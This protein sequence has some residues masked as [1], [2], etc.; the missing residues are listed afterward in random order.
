[1]STT[2][3]LSLRVTTAIVTTT[4]LLG[5]TACAKDTAAGGSAPSRTPSGGATGSPAATTPTPT[6]RPPLSP[7]GFLPKG[8]G[9]LSGLDCPG[10][11]IDSCGIKFQVM[12]IDTNP[13]CRQYGKPAAAGRKT[14]V[15]HVSMTTG[16]LSPD[17]AAV[18]PTIFNPFSL[19]GITRDGFV[20]D[21][22]PG[23]CTDPEGRLSEEILPNAK[24]EGL[25]E[26][27][28]PESVT[29]VASAHQPAPDGGRGWVWPAA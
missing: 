22:K 20:H 19:K 24:Y 28:V 10:A 4:L 8:L 16:T 5:A 3:A 9:Q 14:L 1:V 2:P 25:V 29:S 27:E 26:V 6:R 17:G 23:G 11:D 7:Q 12:R 18:A 15:L 21:A 13:E